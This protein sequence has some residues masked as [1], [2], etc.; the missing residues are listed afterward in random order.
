[1]DL[2]KN[3]DDPKKNRK[4]PHDLFENFIFFTCNRDVTPR[5]FRND[6]SNSKVSGTISNGFLLYATKGSVVW[7]DAR[8]V[9]ERCLNKKI[10]YVLRWLCI[11]PLDFSFATSLA[12]GLKRERTGE[13]WIGGELAPNS[14][15]FPI[16]LSLLPLI[17]FLCL[18]HPLS[19]PSLSQPDLAKIHD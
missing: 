17:F 4:F 13:F 5:T 7:V 19:H 18:R 3:E 6:A 16:V 8:E 2:C 14:L 9:A 11:S 10:N 12:S 1:M 15:A